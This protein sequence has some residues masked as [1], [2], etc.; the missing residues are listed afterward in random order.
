V[1]RGGGDWDKEEDKD[2]DKDEEGADS[3]AL[4]ILVGI[5]PV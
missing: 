2:E 3:S 5:G 1:V 4:L